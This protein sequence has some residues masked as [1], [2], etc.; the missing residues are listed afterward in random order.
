MKGAKIGRRYLGQNDFAAI[1][2]AIQNEQKNY[3]WVVTDLDFFTWEDSLRQKF[4]WTGVFLTGEE[5]TALCEPEPR[6]TFISGVLSAYPKEI[7]IRELQT[8][9]LPE[10]ESPIYWQDDLTL[11][12]SNAV[13]E[14]VPYDGCDLLFLSK[15]DELA[16]LFLQ[17]FPNAVDLARTNRV[18]SGIERRITKILH[19]E[20]EKAGMPLREGLEKLKYSVFQSLC[21]GKDGETHYGVT[22]EAILKSVHWHLD[23]FQKKG[24]ST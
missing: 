8:Y 23:W 10:W 20:A 13:I 3:N 11:Q 22:N 14:I 5:L 19:Q 2:D 18:E 7:S 24:S 17:A 15:R 6:V 12:N 4:S 1:F 9:D 21:L 16:D